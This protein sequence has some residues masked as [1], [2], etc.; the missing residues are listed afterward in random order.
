MRCIIIPSAIIVS[1]L[2]ALIPREAEAGISLPDPIFEG[3]SRNVAASDREIRF[4]QP[5][6]LYAT[7]G[8][9]SYVIGCQDGSFPDFGHLIPGE[10]GGVWAIPIKVLDGFWLKIDEPR[11]GESKW[12]VGAGKFT[13]RPHEC[14]LDYGELLPSL[15]V[16]QKQCDKNLN[17][18]IAHLRSFISREIKRNIEHARTKLTHEKGRLF[19]IKK[20]L[21]R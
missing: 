12:V 19:S 14:E 15:R 21:L 8:A 13:T 2:L 16:R 11:T 1:L 10:M 5:Q 6:G 3:E 9:K 7:L 20:P 17:T 18:R 4:H